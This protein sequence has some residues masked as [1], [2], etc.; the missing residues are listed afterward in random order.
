MT[1]LLDTTTI[2]DMQVP[3]APQI[4]FTDTGRAYTRC[5]KCPCE[6]MLS[7]AHDMDFLA[8]LRRHI[9]AAHA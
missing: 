1:T 2:P 4:G 9:L 3:L 5:P 6:F 8:L 7:S